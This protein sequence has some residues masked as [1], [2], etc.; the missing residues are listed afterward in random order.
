MQSGIPA[1]IIHVYSAPPGQ[2][3]ELPLFN[4]AAFANARLLHPDFEHVLFRGRE[5]AE[6]IEKEFPQYQNAMASFCRPIQRFDF[7]R[8]LAIYRLGGFYFDLDVFLA[9]SLKPLLDHDCV[10]AFEELT[11]SSFLRQKHGMDWEL[12]NYGFGAS[13]ENPFLGAII[14]NCVRALNEPSWAREM[15]QAIPRPF[16]Q[17][18]VA[19]FMTGPGMVSRTFAE[20][21][22]LTKDI[23]ILFPDDVCDERTWHQFGNF[24]VHAQEG[25]W[26]PRTGYLRRR[27]ANLW[28]ARVRRRLLRES[29]ARGPV[30][31]VPRT[32]DRRLKT[33]DGRPK[34]D[35]GRPR[36]D[37]RTLRTAGTNQVRTKN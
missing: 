18:F 1:R 24:G 16:Q 19:P 31:A 17:L 5:M 21:P 11:I 26:R 25:S 34:T 28:E 37:D 36:T 15:M 30:R 12:A 10:F 6:F 3:E 7:F 32:D 29:I 9:R 14:D 27:L 2:P 35:D 13:P 23:T 33:D 22:D 20:N 8:Y 4:Q